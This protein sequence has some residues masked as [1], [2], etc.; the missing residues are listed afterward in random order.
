MASQNKE[1]EQKHDELSEPVSQRSAGR[2][3]DRF[4]ESE[5]F[6]TSYIL[7]P[8]FQVEVSDISG[9]V[10]VECHDTD[11][12]EVRVVRRAA[13]RA[14]LAHHK[15][16][17]ERTATALVVCGKPEAEQHSRAINVLQHVRLKLPRRVALSA[18]RISGPL[19]I[20]K[21][22]G[23]VIINSISGPVTLD[24]AEGESFLSS[25]NGPCRIGTTSGRLEI[26]SLSGCLEV[27]QL[28]GGLRV[29]SVSGHVSASVAALDEHGLH[30]SS[31]SGPVEL[32]F[33]EKVNAELNIQHVSGPIDIDLPGVTCK[34]GTALS[35]V[36]A[37]VGDGSS[38]VSIS[39]VSGLVRITRSV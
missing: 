19:N 10:E 12:A 37:R 29:S 36:C 28:T 27:G 34:D 17:V 1:A 3:D 24:A 16:V 11:E 8:G 18:R 35:S 15:V 39:F 23:P 22:D 32:F 13:S 30:L 14:D 5:Q 4:G 26:S 6:T 21:V 31:I 38:L 20:G 33:A 2:E 7:T 25:L 9:A